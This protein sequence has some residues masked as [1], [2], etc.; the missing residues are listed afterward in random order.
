MHSEDW[1]EELEEISMSE[2]F[3]SVIALCL[4]EMEAQGQN[5][6]SHLHTI[7]TDL[8]IGKAETSLQGRADRTLNGE[9]QCQ[10]R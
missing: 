5:H 1:A 8:V 10:D 3:E 9:G 4:F 2:D 7:L 6:S